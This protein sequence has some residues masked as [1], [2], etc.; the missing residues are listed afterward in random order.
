MVAA[1]LLLLGVAACAGRAPTTEER[2]RSIESRVWSPYCSGRLLVDC[3]TQQANELRGAITDR[4]RSGQSDDDVLAWLRT[5]YGDE[6]LASPK[7]GAAGLALWLVPVAAGL[8][9]AVIVAG[10]VRRWSRTSPPPEQ[11]LPQ[12]LPNRDELLARIRDEV[13]RGR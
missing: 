13:E 1:A 8:A 7:P 3:T 9:G 11:E 2:A 10:A 12:D 4:L 5:N 6:V